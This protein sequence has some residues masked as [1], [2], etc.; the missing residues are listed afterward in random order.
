MRSWRAW[1]YAAV[2]L[3]LAAA[4]TVAVVLISRGV[5][6]TPVLEITPRV[7]KRLI[8]VESTSG[9]VRRQLRLEATLD[10]EPS[11][12]PDGSRLV[13]EG[14]DSNGLNTGLY[15]AD[16]KTQRRLVSRDFFP[17]Q[18]QWSPDGKRIVFVSARSGRI[19][20]WGQAYAIWVMNAD[21]TNVRLLTHNPG[22]DYS[23]PRWSAD[24]AQLAFTVTTLDP[25]KHGKWRWGVGVM[26]SSG[27]RRCLVY[28]ASGYRPGGVD[29]A[30]GSSP[31]S[32]LP[33]RCL[34]LTAP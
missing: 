5:G 9:R 2:G 11:W 26:P 25:P 17:Q 6:R 31:G 4:V 23:N 29:W 20:F 28:V 10:V 8:L 18:A 1:A 15:V 7:G 21:G 27:G 22:L 32:R 16:G 34:S 13:Y 24:G 30:P 3:A 33:H 14:L 12:S 19:D